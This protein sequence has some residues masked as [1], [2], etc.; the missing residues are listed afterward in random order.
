MTHKYNKVQISDIN[1]KPQK[2]ER[3]KVPVD[4]VLIAIALIFFI[5]YAFTLIYPLI[6]GFISS[7][8]GRLEYRRDP[9]GFPTEWLFSN[10]SEA[11]KKISSGGFTFFDMFWNSLW[12]A[13]GSCLISV[14]FQTFYAYV[15]NK[16]VFPG[17]NFLYNLCIFIISVPIGASLVSVY[18]I[19]Y[20]M[21]MMNSPFI[22]FSAT[23]VYGMG[24]IVVYS[25]WNNVSWSYAEAAQIDGA[26][27]YQVFFKAMLPQAKP[28][29]VTLILMGF[30]GK[31]ND[32]MSPMLYLNEMPTLSLGLFRYRTIAE[33]G[34]SYPILFAGLMLCLLP[35]LIIFAIFQ[36]AMMQNMSIGGLKG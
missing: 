18:R 7:F 9:F 6:W 21:G 3:V 5:V 29:M 20:Y 32:Y 22:L 26:N 19:Y 10:Y 28:I 25:Y 13:L 34:G 2:K 23:G 14:F 31:W 35:I 8:K 11:I 12:F 16:Y 27:F 4:K 33:R 17:K 30:I 24:L 1:N 15:L 36:D